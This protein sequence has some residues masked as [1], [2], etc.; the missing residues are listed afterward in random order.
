MHSTRNPRQPKKLDLRKETLRRL[1]SLSDQDLRR[2]N[3]GKRVNTE[4]PS[5]IPT[6]D[7][8]GC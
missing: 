4:S 8:T 5:I 7:D 1:S 3:G 6:S 2:A